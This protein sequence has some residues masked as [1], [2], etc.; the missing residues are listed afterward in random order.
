[1]AL[2]AAN[3]RLWDTVLPH[4]GDTTAQPKT[5]QD[6]ARWTGL[7][8]DTDVISEARGTHSSEARGTHSS[9]ARGTYNSETRD[10]NINETPIPI[11]KLK[12]T[13]LYGQDPPEE[14]LLLLFA[15]QL[16]ITCSNATE[17]VQW[18]TPSYRRPLWLR[19]MASKMTYPID[20]PLPTPFTG[21]YS[22]P[23][24][25]PLAW[26]SNLHR[27]GIEPITETAIQTPTAVVCYIHLQ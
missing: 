2:E 20:W 3:E 14:N 1:M 11:V 21:E 26:C 13:V 27:P 18:A 6:A 22:P 5:S 15:G 7:S 17:I 9:E 16:S 8:D 23:P 24:W 12:G 25:A 19:T 4:F 10:T